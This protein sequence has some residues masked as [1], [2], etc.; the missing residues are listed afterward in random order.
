VTVKLTHARPPAPVRASFGKIAQ[1][2][3]QQR[4]AEVDAEAYENKKLPIAHGQAD[5][6]VQ[7]AEAYK[8]RQIN[9]AQGDTDGFLPV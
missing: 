1:A 7:A 3:E 8:A 6:M 2:R 4:Q 5:Q 9:Q